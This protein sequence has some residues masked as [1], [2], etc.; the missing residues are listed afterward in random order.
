MHSTLYGKG[1]EIGVSSVFLFVFVQ[2]L[3]KWTVFLK[4]NKYK[5]MGFIQS[6]FREKKIKL[7]FQAST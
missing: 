1:R 5:D 2:I 4:K 3:A 7:D 6:F